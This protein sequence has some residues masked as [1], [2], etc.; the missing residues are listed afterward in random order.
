MEPIK[1]LLKN[2][3][4][5]A[6]SLASQWFLHTHKNGAASKITLATVPDMWNHVADLGF[7]KPTIF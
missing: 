7:S 6:I 2:T 1:L 5:S 3:L 4:A